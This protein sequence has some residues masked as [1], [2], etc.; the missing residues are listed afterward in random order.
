VLEQV[1]SIP[2]HDT[3]GA[4]GWMDDMPQRLRDLTSHAPEVV[5]EALDWVSD[6]I[7][8]QG[9][10]WPAAGVVAPFLF[11]IVEHHAVHRREDLLWLLI[12][13][14]PG[15]DTPMLPQG[16]DPEARFAEVARRPYESGRMLA[17]LHEDNWDLVDEGV[18][19]RWEY[20]AYRAVERG[21]DCLM[22][23]TSDA[24][25]TIRMVAARAF[26]WLPTLAPRAVPFIRS[27]AAAE[28]D[29]HVLGSAMMSLGLVDRYAR[30]FGDV[31]HFTERL[32]PHHPLIV[33]RCS[34]LALGTVL[35]E[36]LPP[37]ALDLL[38]DATTDQATLVADAER[39][40]WMCTSFVGYFWRVL[41]S[42]GL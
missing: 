27:A 6:E 23:L 32:A 7:L 4:H 18:W 1:D 30:D 33:R 28:R 2:W 21:A 20:E 40:S 26:W 5:T 17:S 35:G 3:F 39:M 16:I 38:I 29:A 15:D 13:M 8:H 42:L 41:H 9:T 11:E 14:L 22:R 31:P 24:D 37:E 10:V 36:K 19:L 12:G 34:A 25:S